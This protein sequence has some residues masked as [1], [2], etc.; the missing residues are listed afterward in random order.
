MC[1]L[2]VPASAPITSRESLSS[3]ASATVADSAAA[4]SASASASITS[5]ARPSSS[6]SATAAGSATSTSAEATAAES[7][8]T[9]VARRA[10]H[11]LPAMPTP[12]Q[13]K[14]IRQ[15]REWNELSVPRHGTHA[16]LAVYSNKLVAVWD[17]GESGCSIEQTSD[18]RTWH[19]IN[20]QRQYKKVSRP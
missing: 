5:R 4:P 1:Q 6:G 8:R 13:I 18:L 15:R 7:T 12:R 9:S 3:S 14:N 17:I 11:V 19:S 16:V 10:C 2:Q 20:L